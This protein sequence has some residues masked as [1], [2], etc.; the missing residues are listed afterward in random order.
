LSSSNNREKNGY[1]LSTYLKEAYDPA[2]RE[3]LY[4]ILVQFKDCKATVKR[5]RA[6]E[7][8]KMKPTVKSL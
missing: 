1:L 2:R 6:I 4:N 5:V 8:F 7:I 3:I